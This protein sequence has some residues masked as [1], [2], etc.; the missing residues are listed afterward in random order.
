MRRLVPFFACLALASAGCAVSTQ[1][2][3]GHEDYRLY[4]ETR[5]AGTLEERLAA[6]HA[7]LKSMPRGRWKDE[8]KTWFGESEP[9]YYRAAQDSLPRLRAYLLAM[10]DGP[11]SKE[12]KRRIVELETQIGF[13]VRREERT[14]S[15]AREVQAE[16]SS[17]AEQR[18]DLVQAMAEW[19]RLLSGIQSFGE[20]TSSLPHELIYRFRLEEPRGACKGDRCTKTLSFSYSIPEGGRLVERV[21]LFD[22]IFELG[23]VGVLLPG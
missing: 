5:L 15:S 3:S 9:A 8:V 4:R 6:S 16:L 23:G 1:L 21:A 18:K 14:L 22:V 11:H 20:P 13:L 2:A 10:P 19:V 12:V 7:Y 17:A